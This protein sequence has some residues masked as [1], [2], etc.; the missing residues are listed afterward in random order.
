MRYNHYNSEF[1]VIE[2]VLKFEEVD[3]EFA[4]SF[5]FKGNWTCR[6]KTA[7]PEGE[8]VLI[9][10]DNGALNRDVD[11]E[12]ED[13]VTFTGTFSNLMVSEGEGEEG[14]QKEYELVVD[15]DP[16]LADVQGTG[17]RVDEEDEDGGLMVNDGTMGEDSSTCSCLFGN[18]CQSAYNCNNWAGRFEI[19]KANGWSGHS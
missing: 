17:Y 13:E 11:E 7:G 18:P 9:E 2:G 8:E 3:D 5:G 19:A 16:E 14:K 4:I 10:P 15:E 12:D 6:L 1:N